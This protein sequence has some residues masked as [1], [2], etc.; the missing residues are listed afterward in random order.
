MT[1]AST[2]LQAGLTHHRNGNLDAAIEEYRRVLATA[3]DHADAMHF[4]GMALFQKKERPDEA[5][6]LLTKSVTLSPQNYVYINNLGTVWLEGK[7]VEKAIEAFQKALRIRP[8]AADTLANLGKAF[9]SVSPS[10]AVPPLRKASQLRP[11]SSEIQNNLGLAYFHTGNL[12]S[13]LA[14]LRKAVLLDP[15]NAL[16]HAN[17]ARVLHQMGKVAEAEAAVRESLRI[18]TTPEALFYVSVMLHASKQL[19]ESLRYVNDALALAPDF[20][21]A[22][23]AAASIHQQMGNVA[24]AKEH[25]AVCLSQYAPAHVAISA[26]LTIP[27]IQPP[28]AEAEALRQTCLRNLKELLEELQ[29]EDS[30]TYASQAFR[31]VFYFA[32]DGFDAKP[33]VELVS[34]LFRRVYP[35]LNYVSPHIDSSNSE[36]RKARIGFYS[37]F[38]HY[39]NHPVAN[40]FD[41]TLISLSQGMPDTEFFL[42]SAKSSLASPS[43]QRTGYTGHLI[44]VEDDVE[45]ARSALS[46]L[47]LDVLLYLDI[48]MDHLSYFLAHARLAR[49]QGVWGGHPVT[50]GI[51]TIDYFLSL[52]QLEPTDA[53]TH[54]SEKLVRLGSAGF[55][56][57]P[58]TLPSTWKSRTE[59]GLPPEGNLYVCPMK[60]QKLHPSFDE[61]IAKLLE[62]D[63]SG[64]VIL[65]QDHL[66]AAWFAK[67]KAR[68]ELAIKNAVDRERVIFIPWIANE[69]DFLAV[70]REASVVLD[71][72]H[73]GIG[74]TAAFTVAVG[75]PLV[76][77]PGTYMRGRVGYALCKTLQ[78]PECIAENV[79]DYVKKTVQIAQDGKLRQSLSQRIRDNSHKLYEDRLQISSA[80]AFLRSL[81][82]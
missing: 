17:L 51:S 18:K 78:I 32:Y 29:P 41:R 63:S 70:N 42:V 75:T 21:E 20:Y 1:T 43:I 57:R 6:D 35:K 12:G 67:I 46:A 49:H 81:T 14:C 61:A 13:A 19:E 79:S 54:Y 71:P 59:L 77:L 31:N 76:T 52:D 74:T 15:K 7:K 72:F 66:Y 68:L 28:Q 40:A 2:L 25:Y 64:Y 26:A 22:N 3:P 27:V 47:K 5:E 36:R 37:T 53:D 16:A 58:R 24:A 55:A 4:L 82:P 73:F 69:A 34:T 9:L 50:T 11:Q 8:D 39:P 65:F 44:E 48:G 23:F 62:N 80:E 33:A 30:L 56:L 45:A 10:H 38:I 60:L